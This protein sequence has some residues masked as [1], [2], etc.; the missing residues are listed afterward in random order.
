MRLKPDFADALNEL[1]WILATAPD[2]GLRS[3]TEAVQL[4]K[5]ACELAKNQQAAFLTTRSAA[6]AEAGQFPDA[7]AAALR[8]VGVA[9]QAGQ[10]KI[11]AQERGLVE[12]VS[13]RPSFSGNPLNLCKTAGTRSCSQPIQPGSNS[14]AAIGL[15]L[16]LVTAALVLADAAPRLHLPRR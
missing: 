2:A 5:R 1:A 6:Y 8:A 12:T 11:A 9:Q 4:A 15:M 10:K 3:G 13:N 7:M 16:A 14:L